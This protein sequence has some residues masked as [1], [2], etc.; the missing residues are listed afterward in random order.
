V[1]Y[2]LD[3]TGHETVLHSFTGGADGGLPFAGVVR[4]SAGSLFGTTFQGGTGGK[5]V[6]YKLD[7]TGQETVLHNFAGGINGGNPYAGVIL[8]TGGNLLGTTKFGGAAGAGVIFKVDLAGQET[9]LYN[10]TG[11]ADGGYPYAGVI[12]DATGNLYG[13]TFA[14]GNEAS[15]VVF[16][17]TPR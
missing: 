8:D 17:F 3:A 14:G 6:V 4:S 15:G 13:T 10:F 11:A 7:S 9:V 5:G 2:K 1:I 12:L 16:K